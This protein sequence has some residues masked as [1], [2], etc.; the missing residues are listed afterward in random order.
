[1]RIFIIT[2]WFPPEHAPIGQMMLELASGLVGRGHKV[3]VFTGFPNHPSGILFSGYRKRRCHKELINGV[4]VR[5][6]LLYTS[7]KRTFL[8]RLFTSLT[9]ILMAFWAAL[10]RG[11]C[12]AI[13]AVLQPLS[14]GIVVPVLARIKRAKTIFNLQ[15]IHPDALVELGIAKNET[16]ISLLRIIE[17]C[18]YR[19][20]DKIAVICDGFKKNIASK[21]ISP[22][23]VAVIENWVNP[24][25][26]EPGNRMNKFREK[27]RI[28][29]KTF[30][31]LFS[32]T[33]G[34]VSGARTILLTA[35]RMRNE[36][37]L[38]FV[39]V[40]DGPVLPDLKR[41]AEQKNMSNVRFIPFQER[42]S[43]NNVLSSADIAL[44][45]MQK[46][47]GRFSMP[48]K[49]LAYMAAGRPII[50]SVDA[51][52]PTAGQIAKSNSGIIVP[53]EDADLIADAIL[54]LRKSESFCRE[55]GQNGR[56]YIEKYLNADS[57]V[58]KY[59]ALLKSVMEAKC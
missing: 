16:A 50:A 24:D 10:F 22:D 12:D 53:A 59:V 7:P 17:R 45:T 6:V 27:Y 26:I 38:L 13:I 34:Y 5:R 43:L 11:R 28:P 35:D 51:D 1:M 2:Q 49:V 56:I 54:H 36:K 21:G 33:L 52:S 20:S 29:E 41:E 4:D 25:E 30:V 58:D 31:V 9:F 57:A 19:H 32:G 46:G 44:V 3:T 55:L 8:R 23:K 42:S 18:S 15:D 37:D 47:K 48:S 14:V 40:G 39:I